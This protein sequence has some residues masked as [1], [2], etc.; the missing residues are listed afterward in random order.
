MTTPARTVLLTGLGATAVTYTFFKKSLITETQEEAQEHKPLGK[1]SKWGDY[2]GKMIP[3]ALYAGGF[4]LHYLLTKESTSK[5]RTIEMVKST[6]YSGIVTNILKPIA[7]ERRP[8]NHNSKNSFPSGHATTAFAF[9]GTVMM[10]HE[11]YWGVAA[12]GLA[13]FVGYS[14]INDNAHYLHDVMAGATIGLSYA[15]GIHYLTQK[16]IEKSQ[17]ANLQLAPIFL[18]Q[19]YGLVIDYRW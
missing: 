15:I 10:N 14:R 19:T 7:G 8:G 9:A 3:N 4:F 16:R 13:S 12:L 11:W 2:G 5:N 17:S 1:F 18:D 6:L